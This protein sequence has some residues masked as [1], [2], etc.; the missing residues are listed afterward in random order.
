MNLKR[1]NI[2]LRLF[3]LILCAFPASYLTSSMAQTYGWAD[4]LALL[5]RVDKLPEYRTCSYVEQFSSYDRT[6]GNND[7]FNGTYSYLRKEGDKLVIA[8][9]EGPGV[10]NRIWTPTPNDN[11]LYF[12]FDGSQEPGLKI[13]FS[14]LFSGKVF[15]FVKPICGNEVGGFYCYLPITY[16][17]S[18]KIVY[19]GPKL[20]FIQVQYRSL[21][22]TEVKTYDGNITQADKDL[23]NEV[24]ET[25][26]NINPSLQNFLPDKSDCVLCEEKTFTIRPGE[27]IPFFN[28]LRGGRIVGI[29]IDGGDSFEGLNKDVILSALWDEEPVEAIYAP[30]ADFFG[31]AFG[32][33]AMRSVLMGKNEACNYCYLPMPFD[34]SATIKLVY[35]TRTDVKQFPI[36]V[37]TKV[38]YN[39]AKRNAEREGKFYSVWRREKTPLG[40]FHEFLSFKGKGHYVGTIQQAQGLR[41]GMTLFFEGDDSTY[42]DKK[43]RLHGTG[44]EDYYNGGWYALLDRWDRGNSLPLHGCLDYSLPMGRTGGYR[45]FLADKMSFEEEIYHGI[46]HGEVQ[47]NF[48]VD[49][50]S[51]SFF[52]AGTPLTKKED[53]SSELRQVYQPTVHPYFPQLMQLTLGGGVTVRNE[54]G[55]RMTTSEY[56]EVRILLDDVP[57]GKYR[58]LINYFEKPNGA[59]FQV[60]QRQKLLSDWIST[61]KESEEPKDNVYISD[62]E[63]T[64]QTNTITFHVKKTGEGDEFELNLITLERIE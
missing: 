48:P 43:A 52:Y 64:K 18:C 27:E 14:D 39:T 34:K 35:K 33:S 25:W 42:V 13:R 10:I 1:I 20:E 53:P 3:V 29:E 12:Y 24:C 61:Q 54:R 2:G 15:P 47:N 9:M 44:S 51:V 36:S 5:K 62:I 45:F 49:Y 32:K 30:L 55:I 37:N 41:P 19:D 58:M 31:Y 22:D 16:S 21:P 38:Y 8:E 63:L 40:K 4:E 46:E 7:G 60:W 11:M 56:G 28:V 23:L 26:S 17:K 59:S 57:E 50:T 6:W